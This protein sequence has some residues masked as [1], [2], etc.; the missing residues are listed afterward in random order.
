MSNS[1]N[2]KTLGILLCGHTAE[3]LQEEHGKYD[4][5]FKALLGPDAFNYATYAVV[6]SEFPANASTADAWLISGSKHGVYEE[7]DWIPPL[8]SLIKDAYQQNIPMVGICF[9]HQIMAQALG[10]R[11]EKF[12]GGWSIGAVDYHLENATGSSSV[13]LNAWHQ[14]QIVSLPPEAQVIG[15][16]DFCQYA[17]LTYGDKALSMQPHPEFS[18]EYVLGLLEH[19]GQSLSAEEK[20]TVRDASN[21]SLSNREIAVF[22]RDFLQQ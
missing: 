14:D 19:R 9:G 15:S 8:E 12:S 20:Q 6:D 16:N 10:G 5:Q 1:D 21:Q 4:D 11:V 22:L 18:H 7:H 13:K 2:K 3:P 17:A